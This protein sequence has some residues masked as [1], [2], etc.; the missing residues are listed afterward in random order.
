MIVK[1][2]KKIQ[3]F[4]QFERNMFSSNWKSA[5]MIEYLKY[6]DMAIK[7]LIVLTLS[8]RY[9]SR[10]DLHSCNDKFTSGQTLVVGIK[11]FSEFDLRFRKKPNK[12]SNKE[13]FYWICAS[14]CPSNVWQEE[15][16]SSSDESEWKIK[17][18][19][20]NHKNTLKF[21]ESIKIIQIVPMYTKYINPM[22]AYCLYLPFYNK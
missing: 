14:H 11:K 7:Q 16:S 9:S 10:C 2:Q 6:F 19:N 17:F 22:F 20:K 8:F 4:I 21:Y 15:S 12:N 13:S 3:P 1:E 18:V 5:R